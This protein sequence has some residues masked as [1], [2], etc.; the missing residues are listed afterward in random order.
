MTKERVDCTVQQG[1]VLRVEGGSLVVGVARHEA[2]GACVARRA[3]GALSG[4][5]HEV[6]V[7]YSGHDVQ[8]GDRVLL[9]ITNRESFRAL[10]IAY[11]VPFVIVLLGLVVFIALGVREGVAGLVSFGLLVLYYLT[12]Y[13]FRDRLKTEIGVKGVQKLE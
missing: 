7:G 10:F 4:G 12:L 8:V 13:F 11:V 5:M 2:C 9:Q 3:C 6:R 1:V